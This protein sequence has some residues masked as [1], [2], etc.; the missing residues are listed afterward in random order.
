LEFDFNVKPFHPATINRLSTPDLPFQVR[1]AKELEGI[2][3]GKIDLF[4][5]HAGKY[6]ILDWK[7]NFLGDLTSDYSPG[8]IR[9]AMA[10]SNYHLQHLVYTLAVKKYLRLRLPGFDYATH[11]GGVIYLFVRGVRD[12]Q[13]T[14]LFTYR[15]PE[16]LINT[17][18][19]LL[20]ETVA[21]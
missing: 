3:N 14:G 1:Q 8:R 7:S 11:F 12:H 20:G 4:F 19:E 13:D 6:Y 5:E 10:A 18:D 21:G 2:M 17:L 16:A 9:E 15:P